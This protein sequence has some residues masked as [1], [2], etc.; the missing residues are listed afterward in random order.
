MDH[1]LSQ[2]V[3]KSS[4][5]FNLSR[6]ELKGILHSQTISL[7]CPPTPTS[8]KGCFYLTL[9]RGQS[10]PDIML[11]INS[12]QLLFGHIATFIKQEQ[13]EGRGSNCLALQYE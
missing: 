9:T 2:P 13:L 3:I 7:A 8:L 12:R 6:A 10:P 11:Y 1:I 5:E 4:Y